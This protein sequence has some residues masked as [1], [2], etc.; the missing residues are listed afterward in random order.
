VRAFVLSLI[1]AAGLASPSCAS[2]PA[3]G[4]L[5]GDYL[6]G[7]LAARANA[8]DDAA[9]VYAAAHAA[10][11]HETSLL[12]DAFFYQL[13][14]GNIEAAAPY[15]ALILARAPA[16]DDGLA[17]ATIAAR[18]IK[19]G[20]YAEARKTLTMESGATF[21]RSL[22]FL[23]DVWI[24]KELAG[25]DA[26]LRKLADPPADLFG[27]FNQ[28]HE[29]LLAGEAGRVE[30]ARMALEA[31]VAG[32]GGPLAGRAYGALLERVDADKARQYYA[33]L[34][35]E[36]GAAGHA[37]RL[38]GKRLAAGKPSLE[39]MSATAA[40]GAAAAVYSFAVAM[41]QDAAS[42]RERAI[43]AGFRVGEP[44]FNF[45]LVWA[46]LAVYLDPSLDEAR[47]LVGFILSLY[48]DHAGAAAALS[49]I[50]PSSPYF[51]QSRLDMA[52]GLIAAKKMREAE[53]L[54][55]AAIR[56]D[57]DSRELKAA[58]ATLHADQRNHEAA[59]AEF[60]K[61]ID[62][63]GAE[64]PPGAWRYFVARAA[65]LIELDRWPE[66][67]RDL[68]RA[69]N[70]APGEP[71]ALNYLGYSWAER[72][73]HLDE[74]FTLLETAIEKAP[75]SGAIVDSLGWAQYQLGRYEEAV[76]NL[77]KAAAM[78]PSDPTITDHL[79]DAYWRLGRRLEARYQWERALQL[80]PTPVQN[81][82]IQ[83]KL[84]G[85]LKDEPEQRAA[86]RRE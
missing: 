23:A 63:L 39:F 16:E 54:L 60:D 32:L 25:P 55:K 21:I 45:P 50:P 17:R 64:T 2:A 28:Y 43:E 5:S 41:I 73:L 57:A 86:D 71:T 31:A 36:D 83:S 33:I 30:Q 74:A 68:K 8:L 3:K 51:A 82:A 38:A 79:G 70:L 72:G 11:P 52:T 6:S 19:H 48:G 34:A 40:E 12:K 77:E 7:R 81:R 42:E 75:H 61:V 24:E 1:V 66:A 46:R 59:V 80:E 65:S 78:E 22:A 53:R 10:A 58:L 29:G 15:A 14:A 26:A 13:A 20:D 18:Q 27:G 56:Q 44:R 69:V 85:G 67:E 47:H 9:R 76:L 4:S 84:A 35:L 49:P 62:S 37:A